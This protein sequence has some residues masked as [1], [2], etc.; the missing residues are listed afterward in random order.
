MPPMGAPATIEVLP[1]FGDGLFRLEKHSHIWVLAWLDRA[2]R[3]L[4]RVVPRGVAP[5][6]PDALHGVFAVRSPVRPNSIGLTATRVLG[7]EGLRV[8]VDPLDFLDGTPVVD[9]KPYFSSRDLIFSAGNAQIGR[10]ASRE[11]LRDSLLSQARKLRDRGKASQAL[12][13]YGKAVE[14]QPLN[15]EALAGR[16]WCYLD[17]SQY[18]PAEASF[19]AALEAD[20]EGADA[21]LGL[22][23]TLRYEGKRAD[24]VKFYERYLAAHPDGE[25]AVAARNAIQQLKE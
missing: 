9:L 1:E 2:D 11:A 10:P 12:E 25:D 6:D 23:E 14:Q 3:S 24:A 13:L 7:V 18:A 22:A 21:L 8:D 5:T 19:Q 20:P 16:G 15:A 17:L 4:L